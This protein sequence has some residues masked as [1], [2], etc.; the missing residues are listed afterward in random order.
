MQGRFTPRFP[1]KYKG[2]VDNII[3]RSSWELSAMMRFDKDPN[4]VEWASEEV[5]EGMVIPYINP[6]DGRWHRYFVDF[7]IKNKRGE[8]FLIEIKPAS[9]VNK[10][11]ERNSK[12]RK[13]QGRVFL[14]EMVEWTKNQAKWE[15]ARKFAEERNWKFVVLTEKELGI[16]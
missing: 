9:Q 3:Y 2:D 13:R 1:E 4:I 5:S 8:T 15:Y 16:K 10:P 7:K 11:Q 6:V 14:G 12:G